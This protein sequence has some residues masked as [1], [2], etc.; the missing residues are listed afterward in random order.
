MPVSGIVG[1]AKH[2]LSSSTI[3]MADRPNSDDEP[4]KIKISF[5]YLHIVSYK[6]DFFR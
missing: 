4:S 3:E 5:P 6:P 1:H 2:R